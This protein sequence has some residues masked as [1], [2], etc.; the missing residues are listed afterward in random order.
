[1]TC[2]S[3]ALTFHSATL[4]PPHAAAA[5]RRRSRRRSNKFRLVAETTL[6]GGARRAVRVTPRP[7]ATGIPQP[8]PGRH[9]AHAATIQPPVPRPAASP[10]A[11]SEVH[12]GNRRLFEIKPQDVGNV[13][14]GVFDGRAGLSAGSRGDPRWQRRSQRNMSSSVPE[15][16]GPLLQAINRR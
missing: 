12:G 5:R 2:R 9:R 16:P 1:M 15:P 3:S 4:R 8:Q 6:I 7:R 14:I 11:I 13:V 10:P